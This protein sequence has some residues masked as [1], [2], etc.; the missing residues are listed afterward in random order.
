MKLGITSNY[1]NRYGWK[2]GARRMRAHGYHC[3]DYQNFVSTE[4][5]FFRLA[6]RD[7]KQRLKEER[8][9]L[10]AEGITVFQA[11]GPWR[12]PAQDATAEDR[13][14]R[15]AAMSKAI[16]GSAYLGAKAMVI[17]PLM[18]YGA[19]SAEHPDEVW[20]INLDFFGSLCDVAKEYNVTLCYENMPFLAFPIHSA[21][22]V[23]DFARQLQNEHFKVCL[24]TG[25]AI[26]C[27]EPLTQAVATI[28]KDLLFALHVH[29]NDGLHDRHWL[30]CTG[31]GDWEGFSKALAAIGFDGVFSFE[32]SVRGTYSEEE[33]ERLER[34][35]A[36]LGKRLACMDTP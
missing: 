27:G 3:L 7:F 14:E 11:H 6:E 9:I 36:R 21:K 32:T 16:R 5:D 26:R 23:A 22:H 12:F 33:Q 28:G 25:H 10:Y 19:K 1:L 24:D 35:L 30:P 34:E 4:T 17:H 15:F 8:E 29:D 31:I 13:T 18:P 20:Q 2:E